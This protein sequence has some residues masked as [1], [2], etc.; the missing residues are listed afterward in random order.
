M[1][2]T[3][4][5]IYQITNLVTGHCYIGSAK[6]LCARW[7]SHRYQ[8]ERGFHHNPRLQ[9]AW[10][11]Y[12]SE[13]FRFDV[14]EQLE[15]TSDLMRWEQA[16]LDATNAA[17]DESF[18][19]FCEFAGS[20]LG[21]K[22]SAETRRRLSQAKVG[23][24]PTPEAREKMRAAKLGKKLTAEHRAKIGDAGRGRKLL[25]RSTHEKAIWRKISFEA[26]EKIRQL[27]ARGEKL[28]ALAEQFGIARASVY[29]IVH[30]KSYANP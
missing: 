27:R 20:H 28:Q 5:G 12:G 21:R 7:S 24:S 6:S 2:T 3:K 14:L 29:R 11:K 17:K 1:I 22:R 23:N 18:Y 16:Y 26:A 4:P 19:N 13:A 25:P 10:T 8:L 15:D 30:G 9:A